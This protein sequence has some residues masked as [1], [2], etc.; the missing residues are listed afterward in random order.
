MKFIVEDIFSWF[1]KQQPKMQVEL[2]TPETEK[3]NTLFLASRIIATGRYMIES[4]GE[5][6]GYD[7]TIV[8]PT[9][10]E[11]F[12]FPVV[13][14]NDEKLYPALN[15][16]ILSNRQAC[17]GTNLD[18]YK[19]MLEGG[20]IAD[21]AK[22]VIDPFVAWQLYYDTF[23][24]PPPWG[25]RAHGFDGDVQSIA[26]HLSEIWGLS[27]ERFFRMLTEYKPK[28][29]KRCFCGSGK[30]FRYC[31]GKYFYPIRRKITRIKRMTPDEYKR[32]SEKTMFN[33]VKSVLELPALQKEV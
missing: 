33:L 21:F 30:Q 25:E 1:A 32:D 8:L 23:G 5:K 24:G 7:L 3:D 31:H 19:V 28:K 10:P 2:I 4:N 15:R 18:I 16:H 6:Y 12:F 14:C 13:F 22:K 9:C 17:L 11:N 26:E 20:G 27:G 29:R